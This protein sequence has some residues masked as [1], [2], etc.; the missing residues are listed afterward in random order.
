MGMSATDDGKG[1]G[2]GFREDDGGD[3]FS[4]CRHTLS[5]K[6]ASKSAFLPSGAEK[7]SLGEYQRRKPRDRKMLSYLIL[8]SHLR[9]TNLLADAAN[10]DARVPAFIS[11]M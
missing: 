5:T 3:T 9:M 11:A 4:F 10:R 1:K 8:D 2:K 7:E 6:T